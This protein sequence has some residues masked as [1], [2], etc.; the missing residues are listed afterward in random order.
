MAQE[1]GLHHIGS[2]DL[3]R[4]LRALHREALSSPITRSSLIEK[5]FGDQEAHLD[6]LVGRDIA[7]AKAIIIAVLAERAGERGQ[8]A[9]LSY[10]GVPSP[11]TRSRDLADQVRELIASSTQS[12]ELYGLT[13]AEGPELLRTLGALM[14]GRDVRVRLVFDVAREQP[15]A[16][17]RAYVERVLPKR[18]LLEVFA[19]VGARLRARVAIVD[20]S[21]VLVTS[22]GLSAVEEDGAVDIGVLFRDHTYVQAWAS[23][24]QRLLATGACV[25]VPQ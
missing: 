20:E 8:V 24:W 3:K 22:G 10:C 14:G 19:C 6:L 12:V 16:E 17:L 9:S 13:M 18:A 5:A 1:F 15:L 2:N 25:P 23:E 4:L 21:K 7:A 11:G